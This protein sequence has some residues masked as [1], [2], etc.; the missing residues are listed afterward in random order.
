MLYLIF[1]LT[2]GLYEGTQEVLLPA[3]DLPQGGTPPVNPADPCD[4][5][6]LLPM[7]GLYLF[8]F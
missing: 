3:G 7:T 8:L 2:T 5:K 6:G 4:S 1:L